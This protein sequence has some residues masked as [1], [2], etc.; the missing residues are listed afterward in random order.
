MTGTKE[1][2]KQG[3]S[4][5]GCVSSANARLDGRSLCL[6]H[7]HRI[8]TARLQD[9]GAVLEKDNMSAAE[10]SA[11]LGFLSEIVNESTRV[12]AREKSL[13]ESQRKQYFDLSRQASEFFKR[14]QRSPR[15]R[16]EL[17]V[18]LGR[19]GESA[20]RGESAKT[21]NV[22]KRG[23]CVET[24]KSWS[25]GETIWIRRTDVLQQTRAVIVWLKVLSP[26]KNLTGLRILD[27]E[28]FWGLGY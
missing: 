15:R 22:S 24:S 17:P 23:A 9:Y 12:T 16:R 26:S 1:T 6:N 5:Q 13:L 20:A 2:Q 14:A 18:V 8:A 10:K 28:D 27:L 11:M 25:I 3:C 21:V 4:W 19:Q 7:F